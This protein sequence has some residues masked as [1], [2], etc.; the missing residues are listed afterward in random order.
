MTIRSRVP[1]LPYEHIA[2]H[3]LGERYQLSL[4]VCGDTLARRLNTQWRKKTY[5]PNVL[6]FP[7]DEWSGEVIL[8]VR[9]AE[10]EARAG[11]V[12]IQSR[13]ALLF[14]HACYH[15]KGYDHSDEMEKREHRTLVHFGFMHS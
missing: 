1:R 2:Q 15:L 6:S 10:R 4:L 8:N 5:T 13:V 12:S 11:G 3:I 9:K 7:Y 14:V